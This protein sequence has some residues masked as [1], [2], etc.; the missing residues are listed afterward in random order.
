MLPGMAQASREA[1]FFLTST[2]ASIVDLMDTLEER[3]IIHNRQ[4]NF[5]WLSAE[6]ESA[7]PIF[8]CGGTHMVKMFFPYCWPTNSVKRLS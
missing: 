3:L 6:M 4:P 2:L 8:V 1:R 5:A 7:S